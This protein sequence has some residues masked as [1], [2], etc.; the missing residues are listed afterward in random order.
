MLWNRE[1][2]NTNKAEVGELSQQSAV[3]I[4]TL[5]NH[6]TENYYQE[7]NDNE[8]ITHVTLERADT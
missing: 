1:S 8:N 2:E 5:M 6:S 4:H 7:K 3:N